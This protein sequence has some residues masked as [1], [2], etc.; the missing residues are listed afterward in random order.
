MSSTRVSPQPHMPSLFQLFVSTEDIHTLWSSH[1]PGNARGACLVLPRLCDLH[2]G[3]ALRDLAF[4]QVRCKDHDNLFLKSSVV[5][6]V[7][8]TPA[9]PRPG[10]PESRDRDQLFMIFHTVD[11]IFHSL[12]CSFARRLAHCSRG[13]TPP[14]LLSGTAALGKSSSRT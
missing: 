8:A 10:A 2:P 11:V 3:Y 1:S 6:Q 14:G 4:L 12:N 5:R 7:S 13:P 9:S